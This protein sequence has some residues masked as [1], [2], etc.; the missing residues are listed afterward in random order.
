MPELKVKNE[1]GQW[2]PVRGNAGP[3]GPKGDANT[4]QV[5]TVDST[6]GDPSVE[7]VGDSPNQTV[8]FL[9][10]EGP[11][12]P[13][14]LNG[15]QGIQGLKGDKGDPGVGMV[16]GG[17]TGQVLRKASNANHDAVWD[18][19]IGAAFAIDAEPQINQLV[20]DVTQN[21]QTISRIDQQVLD[22][23]KYGAVG[24]G[25][26][27]DT[28]A[29][30]AAVAAVPGLSGSTAG[31]EVFLPAGTYRVSATI[32]ASKPGVRIRGASGWGTRLVA[33]ASLTA[34]NP[35]IRF[36]DAPYVV[37]G[38]QVSD[39]QIDM[40]ESAGNGI[41]MIGAYDNAHLKD[42]LIHGLSGNSDGISILHRVSAEAVD[43]QQS[44]W[45]MNVQVVG[46]ADAFTGR[47]WRIS[48]LQEAVFIGCKGIGGAE[49]VSG[50]TGWYVDGCLGIVFQG[51][52]L[53][54]A[55]VGM[56]IVSRIDRECG[57]ITIDTP[58]MEGLVNGL[59]IQGNA[60]HKVSGVQLRNP[61]PQ[62]GAG[63]APG[64]GGGTI[65][66]DYATASM[67]ET[68]NFP[69]TI[70]ATCTQV[71]VTTLDKSSV[72]QNGVES[73]LVELPN[74]VNGGSLAVHGGMRI[75]TSATQEGVR[76][77]TPNENF[78]TAMMVYLAL[79]SGSGM[80]WVDVGDVDTAGVG[81]RMLRVLN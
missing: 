79:P 21:Q 49:T 6:T 24:D 48:N 40:T 68:R 29:I 9:L 81:Y 71:H 2:I 70:T 34:G 11:Q 50:G 16:S 31:V 27:D 28:A 56:T 65:T 72:T 14:G 75:Y 35:V 32:E 77:N 42:I 67:L 37:R 8:N 17:E 61:R 66:A 41:E 58:T 33:T 45:A 36:Q 74:A 76:V 64:Q 51:C 10:K 30:Q 38:P 53:A 63:I 15:P 78:R 26:A 1:L 60:T 54:R 69:T 23:K 3:R 55:A 52:S 80:R 13:Q 62:V 25:V 22:V 7:I 73:L 19:D 59:N 39:L 43:V 47:A 12:G 18:A 20:T 46:K 4:L 57:F 5:G 44:L